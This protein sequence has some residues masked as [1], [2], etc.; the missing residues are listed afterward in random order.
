[1]ATIISEDLRNIG[2]GAQFTPVAFNDLVRRLDTKP[3]K[4]EACVLGFTGSPE[5]HS[6]ANIWKSSGRLHQWFPRQKKPAT[7]WEAEIDKIF[8]D[9]AHE[10]DPAKRKEIYG[11]W[12]TICGEQQPMVA[13]VVVEAVSALRN[14]FGNIKPTSLYFPFKWNVDEIFE[15]SA[16]R[17]TP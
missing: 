16:T 1:M 15:R 8:T 10:M 14:K 5:L 4:W 3:Y 17:L 13:T 12:Q 9:G 2:L 6:G 11:R 7:P